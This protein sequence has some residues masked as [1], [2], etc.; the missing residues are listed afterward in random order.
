MYETIVQTVFMKIQ[1]IPTTSWGFLTL[2]CWLSYLCYSFKPFDF[3]V[4]IKCPSY[5]NTFCNHTMS[6]KNITYLSLR[7]FLTTTYNWLKPRQWLPA[8]PNGSFLI[9]FLMGLLLLVPMHLNVMFSGPQA[10][11]SSAKNPS[12]SSGTRRNCPVSLVIKLQGRGWNWV[13]L[14]KPRPFGNVNGS[15]GFTG[16]DGFYAG[17]VTRRWFISVG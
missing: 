11:P 13:R 1:T 5:I 14:R 7:R 15:F 8:K 6:T 16:S 12:I 17:S 4:Q 10:A 9:F 3:L 2:Y